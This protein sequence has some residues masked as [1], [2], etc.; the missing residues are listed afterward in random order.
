M[1]KLDE[2]RRHRLARRML[3]RR[4]TY[5]RDGEKVYVTY[6][7]HAPGTHRIHSGMPVVIV[8]RRWVEMG[9][10]WVYDTVTLWGQQ[11][12]FSNHWLQ[13]EKPNVSRS[14]DEDYPEGNAPGSQD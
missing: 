11:L 5:F 7:A 9:K 1:T 4:G 10:Q 13:R 14:Q 2:R 6:E 3:K 8:R 12:V